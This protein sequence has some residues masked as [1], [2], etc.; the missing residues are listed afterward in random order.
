M[1]LLLDTHALLWLLEG[2][3][4][5]SDNARNAIQNPE[6]TCFLS[7]VSLWEIAIKIS[8]GKLTMK[9]NFDKLPEMLYENGIE[10]LDI[11]FKHYL[12]L[13]NIPFYHKDPFDRLI[14]AQAIEEKMQVISCDE[15]FPKYEIEL[16]W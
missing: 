14:L 16:I 4:S 1:N 6:N 7:T 9:T 11:N 3:E 12:E 8:I 13:L 15:N 10:L 2:E 5:L